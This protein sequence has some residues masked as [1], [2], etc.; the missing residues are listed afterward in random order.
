MKKYLIISVLALLMLSCKTTYVV[1]PSTM[2]VKNGKP[3]FISTG[4]S[5]LLQDTTISNVYLIHK[6]R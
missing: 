2:V 6:N 4:K 5:V 1:T 3:T